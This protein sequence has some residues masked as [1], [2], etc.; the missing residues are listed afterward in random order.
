MRHAAD[1]FRLFKV[2]D[3]FLVSPATLATQS[4][5]PLA[6]DT[7]AMMIDMFV[8]GAAL[9]CDAAQVLRS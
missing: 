8:C 9:Q 3:G 1:Q 6:P 7:E 4:L 5:L 2:L